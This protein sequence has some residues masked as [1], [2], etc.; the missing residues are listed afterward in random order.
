MPLATFLLTLV[1]ASLRLE[2]APLPLVGT[3]VPFVIQTA[4]QVLLAQMHS[5]NFAD[6]TVAAVNLSRSAKL[7][8]T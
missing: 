3:A 1:A 2:V 7:V 4:L 5:Q 8:I 6:G